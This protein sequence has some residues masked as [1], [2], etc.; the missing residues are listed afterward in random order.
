[1]GWWVNG[2]LTHGANFVS[3]TAFDAERAERGAE[4]AEQGFDMPGIL[5]D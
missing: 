1:M 5:L 4:I 3:A 2:G